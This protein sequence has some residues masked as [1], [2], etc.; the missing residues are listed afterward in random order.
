[1]SASAVGGSSAGR[2]CGFP[3]ASGERAHVCWHVIDF[4]CEPANLEVFVCPWLLYELLLAE[5]EAVILVYI[6]QGSK[7]LLYFGILNG[8]RAR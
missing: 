2:S 3:C 7:T 5:N 4:L 8:Y 1:M 6:E